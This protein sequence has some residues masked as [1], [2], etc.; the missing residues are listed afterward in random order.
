M[1]DYI[2]GS[3]K[4]EHDRLRHQQLVWGSYS[5]AAIE[6]AFP[7]CD[8][9]KEFHVADIG[10]GIGLTLPYMIEHFHIRNNK[11]SRLYA[12]EPSK[13]SAKE[14]ERI[15]SPDVKDQIKIVVESLQDAHKNNSIPQ[16]SL[17]CI[18]IRWVLLYSNTVEQDLTQ[19]VSWLK[20]GG[21]LVIQDYNHDSLR[22]FPTEP[23]FERM[24]KA[25]CDALTKQ[26]GD[27]H[28]AT[29][30]PQLFHH[31][32]NTQVESIICNVQSGLNKSDI[33]EWF[34]SFCK[35]HSKTF[36]EVGVI[37][38]SECERFKH[39]WERMSEEDGKYLLFSPMVVDIIIK[40]L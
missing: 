26:K 18:F 15:I 16:G 29:K 5:Y 33:W 39:E 19:L 23:A 1:P 25:V 3:E 6:R 14:I 34:G 4:Q 38:K 28:V 9:K 35:A 20:P 8:I 21:K 37:D 17:D 40:N 22:V 13:Q 32:A 12:L 31:N 24:T 30:I 7:V 10:A 27:P 11:S 36:I 2:L